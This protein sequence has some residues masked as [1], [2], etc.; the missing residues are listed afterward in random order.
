MVDPY[1][2]FDER[3]RAW[4][5]TII[6]GMVRDPQAAN[7]A[8]VR[9]SL[10]LE[11]RI[12]VAPKDAPIF[13]EEVCVSLAR[14]LGVVTGAAPVVYLEGHPHAGA[15]EAIKATLSNC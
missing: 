4:F 3:H 1:P 15:Q 9:G 5:M 6:E 10:D 7:F 11:I 8:R 2:E 12:R 13:T 14:L